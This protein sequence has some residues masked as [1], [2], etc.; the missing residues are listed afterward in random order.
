MRPPVA[1]VGRRAT[2]VAGLRFS[3]T[4]AAEAM[5]EAVFAAGG[6]PLVLHGGARH[7]LFD[8]P[9]RLSVF[10]GVVLPG[11]SD[12][13]PV[14]YNQDPHPET[15]PDH[16][17]QDEL[18]FAVVRTVI[19]FGI[20]ALAVCRGMQVL[21]IACGG[22]L[23]QHLAGGSIEHLDTLHEVTVEPGSRL[24]AVVGASAFKVSSY[25]HQAIDRLGRGLNVVARSADGCV[26]AV[27]HTTADVLAVQ[28]HPEDLADTSRHD[29]ALFSDLIDRARTRK[30]AAA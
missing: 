26:E 8:L 29:G 7:L 30:E 14:R 28:W 17:D 13:N 6:E 24:A 20:P 27:E 2:S 19:G 5:C 1:V 4:I 15:H 22:T 25:H 11:G 23:K 21:N 3:G 18:D 16:D 9:R 12:V 10:A